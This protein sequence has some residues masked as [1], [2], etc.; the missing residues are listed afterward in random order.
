MANPL[1]HM[2][3]LDAFIS[4]V[5]EEYQVR[6]S[7]SSLKL[8]GSRGRTDIEYL[9]REINGHTLVALLPDSSLD[10]VLTPAVLQVLCDALQIPL[11]DFGLTL[12]DVTEETFGHYS[13][14]E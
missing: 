11:E 13:D 2:P 1:A 5:S 9:C 4:R 10:I 12:H 8:V 6:K 7:T 14:E 3:T